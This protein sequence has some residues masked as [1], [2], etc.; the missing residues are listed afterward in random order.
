MPL[1][2][3]VEEY[4]LINLLKFTLYLIIAKEVLFKVTKT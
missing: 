1:I 3:F 4:Y 2:D